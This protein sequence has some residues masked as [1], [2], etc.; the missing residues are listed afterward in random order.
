MSK[1]KMNIYQ[2]VFYIISFII[3][4]IAFILLGTHTYDKKED[5]ISDALK[6]TKEFGIEENNIYIYKSRSEILECLNNGS[7]LIFMAF[8]NDW[9]R[10]YADLLNEVAKS[11]NIKEIYYYNFYRDRENNN[12]YYENIVEHLKSYTTILDDESIDIYSPTLV[13]V[14]NGNIIFFDN[15]TS[16][17]NG[18]H[19]L[20][21]YWTNDRVKM[22]KENI[23]S[24]IRLFKGNLS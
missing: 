14:K 5:N 6:F 23:R 20:K 10:Y 24:A 13:I 1:K 16:I 2:K 19:T 3:M 9:S 8:D 21:E 18:E 15:E 7:A 4:I 22:K 12:N 11:E 17:M